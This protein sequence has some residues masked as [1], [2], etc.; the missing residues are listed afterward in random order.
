MTRANDLP[1][2]GAERRGGFLE[3]RLEVVEH[4]LHG[5]HDE[6]QADEDQRDEDAERREGDLDAERREQLPSQPLSA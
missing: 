4:R 3:L 5:A 6:R 1:A 2:V